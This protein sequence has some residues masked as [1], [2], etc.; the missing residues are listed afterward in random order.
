MENVA[1]W[2]FVCKRRLLSYVY[3]GSSGLSDCI[4]RVFR[5]VELLF[6]IVVSANSVPN[7]LVVLGV[8]NVAMQ[9]TS[10]LCKRLR[11]IGVTT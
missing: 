1:I 6:Y 8:G 10:V 9:C 11:S 4:R 3:G 7:R 5:T 2:I